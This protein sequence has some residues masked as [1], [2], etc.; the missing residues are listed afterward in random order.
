M[1]VRKEGRSSNP[2]LKETDPGKCLPACAW[3][4]DWQEPTGT[5]QFTTCL[6]GV[7][8]PVECGVVK[9]VVPWIWTLRS[10]F[11]QMRVPVQSKVNL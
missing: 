2:K 10:G 6:P 9:N 8:V 7:A 4:I 5:S 1:P 11:K 3:L